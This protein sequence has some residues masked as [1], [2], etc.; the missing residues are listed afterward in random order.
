MGFRRLL[1]RLFLLC[2]IFGAQP[3]FAQIPND[4]AR[5]FYQQR[6]GALAWSG[7]AKATAHAQQALAVLSRA[8]SEG[9]DPANYRTFRDGDDRAANDASLS[10]ALLA[11]MRDVSI[12]RPELRA[13]DADVG[14]QTR[15]P[16]FVAMLEDA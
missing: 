3:S 15:S 12:G 16:D 7:D 2:A 5:Q 9:L 11:Y 10:R 6:Q 1:T 13:V 14:L 4:L 8:A